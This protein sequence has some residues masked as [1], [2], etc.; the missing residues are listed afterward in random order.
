MMMKTL[1]YILITLMMTTTFTS[2]TADSD[3]EAD[4]IEL[5]VEDEVANNETHGH[6]EDEDEG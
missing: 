2:C 4:D 6:V 5:S 3:S 1:F